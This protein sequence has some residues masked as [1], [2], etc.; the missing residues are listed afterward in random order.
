VHVRP[1]GALSALC[2]GLARFG[3][4]RAIAIGRLR[5]RRA[6]HQHRVVRTRWPIR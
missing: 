1:G 2:R 4:A 5:A 6:G 3:R